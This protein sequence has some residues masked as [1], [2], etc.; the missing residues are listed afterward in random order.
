MDT[1]EYSR[2]AA[3]YERLHKDY[4][5]LDG[6]YREEKQRLTDCVLKKDMQIWQMQLELESQRQEI[7][8]L[9]REQSH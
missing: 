6:I 3:A 2:L 5:Y 8:R 4:L 1:A 9:T 7:S